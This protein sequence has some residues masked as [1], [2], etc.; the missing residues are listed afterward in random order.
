MQQPDSALFTDIA[1][2]HCVN[3]F[4][5][6]GRSDYTLSRR[7][8]LAACQRLRHGVCLRAAA[9]AACCRVTRC[10]ARLQEQTHT[11]L[12]LELCILTTCPPWGL[13]HHECWFAIELAQTYSPPMHAP[14][15][16][17]LLQDVQTRYSTSCAPAAAAAGAVRPPPPGWRLRR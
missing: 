13:R 1:P 9:T 12:D 7:H 16:S 6:L 2:T 11:Q 8:L 17:K 10:Q 4:C 3:Q 15:T 5:E 14:H